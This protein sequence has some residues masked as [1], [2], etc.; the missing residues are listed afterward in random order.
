MYFPRM[1]IEPPDPLVTQDFIATVSNP[2]VRWYGGHLIDT[3]NGNA[4]LWLHNDAGKWKVLSTASGAY[5]ISE[6]S[7]QTLVNARDPQ[8]DGEYTA[9]TG[10]HYSL[11]PSGTWAVATAVR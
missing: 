5:Q 4:E 1:P 10:Q 11:H 3:G 6:S 7:F 8:S 2:A 9:S